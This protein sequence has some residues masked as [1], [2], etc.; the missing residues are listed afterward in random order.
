VC[1]SRNSNS[2]ETLRK[3]HFFIVELN[4]FSVNL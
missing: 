2:T 3:V 1:L 4:M